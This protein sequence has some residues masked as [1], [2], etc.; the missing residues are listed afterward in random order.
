MHKLILALAALTLVSGC[1]EEPS[2]VYPIE[3]ADIEYV[4]FD[5]TEGIY[6]STTVADSP[7]NPFA[8]SGMDDVTKWEVE[9][10]GAA[11]AAFYSWAMVNL[12]GPHGEAQ[13]YTAL[14]LQRIFE[15]ELTAPEDLFRLRGMAIDAYQAV[16]DNW[17][18]DVT[19]AAEGFVLPL[20]LLAFDGIVSLGG[21]PAGWVRITDDNGN[22]AV[23]QVADL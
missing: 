1:P 19:Y 6:P 18:D 7:Y 21:Y 11:A 8:T 12:R 23:I 3:L 22:A 16:L 20:N 10:S 2:Y 14:N 4:F 17:P 5:E 13:F 15:R 9:A